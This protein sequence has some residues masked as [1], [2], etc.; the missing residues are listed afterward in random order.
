MNG[1]TAVDATTDWEYKDM[2]SFLYA[3]F[4]NRLDVDL[5]DKTVGVA[6]NNGF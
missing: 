6:D 1:S 5:Y 4:I 2:P 3:C